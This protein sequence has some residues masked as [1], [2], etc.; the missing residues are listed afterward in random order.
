MYVCFIHA[1]VLFL[2]LLCHGTWCWGCDIVSLDER[3][4]V[5]ERIVVP[6]TCLEPL[7]HQLSIASQRTWI[8]SHTA[9]RTSDL[10]TNGTLDI[11]NKGHTNF[12]EH[13][14][15]VQI[16]N[17][18]RVNEVSPI[19]RTHSSDVTCETHNYLSLSA[20]R[21]CNDIHFEVRKKK[22]QWLCPILGT[23]IQNLITSRLKFYN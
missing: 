20:C 19:L 3:V 17:A 9:V 21:I 10:M 11:P 14:S 5:F 12:P 15:H 18:R 13:V 7:T 1:K 22:L 2:L 8:V 4:L 6:A 16:L 23:N